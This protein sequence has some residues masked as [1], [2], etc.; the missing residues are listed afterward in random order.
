VE[1][2]DD[3]G[4]R[5]RDRLQAFGEEPGDEGQPIAA[6]RLGRRRLEWSGAFAGEAKEHVVAR[7]TFR[8]QATA[9]CRAIAGAQIDDAGSRWAWS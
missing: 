8:R 9:E 2:R 1:L 5:T 6:H 7:R 4:E 3:V